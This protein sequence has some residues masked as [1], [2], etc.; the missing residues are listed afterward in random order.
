MFIK[1]IL[2]IMLCWCRFNVGGDH[3]RDPCEKMR[4]TYRIR[5]EHSV[6]GREAVQ[7]WGPFLMLWA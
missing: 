1:G 6:S 4:G 3:E 5:V 7:L 2:V